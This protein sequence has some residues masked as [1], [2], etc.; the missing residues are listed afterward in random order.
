MRNKKKQIIIHFGNIIC[1][2]NNKEKEV[3][4]LIWLKKVKIFPQTKI[5]KLLDFFGLYV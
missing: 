4:D 3:N 2:D 1:K 5:E